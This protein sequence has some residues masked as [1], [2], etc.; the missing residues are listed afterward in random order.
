MVDIRSTRSIIAGIFL[1]ALC[2]SAAQAQQPVAQARPE[3]LT[4]LI[5]CRSIA[6]G[7]QRLACYD[8]AASAFDSAEKQGDVV[9]VDREQ[10]SVARRQLFG[11]QLPSMPDILQRGAQP[12]VL[13]SIETTLNRAGQY[14]D[15]KWTFSLADGSTWRQIDSEPVRFQNRAGQSVRVRR[16]A[17]GSFLLTVDGSRA[18]R[19]RRQ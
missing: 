7:G 15:G 19:V 1:V 16:A 10:V 14:G 4:R 11:F 8:A 2:A 17:L 6:D 18:V 5:D 9:V 3:L 12:D 13:D